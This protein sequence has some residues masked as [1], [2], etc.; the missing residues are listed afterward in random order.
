VSNGRIT[1]AEVRNL[2]GGRGYTFTVTV[3]STRDDIKRS[4]ALNAQVSKRIYRLC[5]KQTRNSSGD[6]IAKRDLMI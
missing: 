1:R 3:S 2:Y 5:I 6:E 4:H